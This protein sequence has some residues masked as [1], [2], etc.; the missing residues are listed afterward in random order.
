MAKVSARREEPDGYL[1]R[2]SV[3]E[4][5]DMFRRSHP[6][7]SPPQGHKKAKTTGATPVGEKADA[8]KQAAELS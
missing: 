6:N 8:A 4:L 5:K 1:T 2:R 3:K 7:L